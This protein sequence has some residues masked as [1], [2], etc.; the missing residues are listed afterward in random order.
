MTD[1]KITMDF[2]PWG[3][4]PRWFRTRVE[5]TEKIDPEGIIVKMFPDE[6][7]YKIT[8]DNNDKGKWETVK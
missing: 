6:N 3:K 7:V 2:K 4:T 8:L 5:I 1:N